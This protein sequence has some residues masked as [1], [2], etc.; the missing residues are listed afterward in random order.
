MY[1]ILIA[2]LIILIFILFAP[3]KVQLTFKDKKLVIKASLLNIPVYRVKDSVDEQKKDATTDEKAATYTRT[4][5]NLG[6]R[7]KRFADGFPTAVRMVRKYVG[8]KKIAINVELGTGDA[9]ITAIST[10]ALWAT[11]YSV[12]GIIGSVAYIDE[13]KVEITP[14]YNDKIFS[15]DIDCIIKSRIVYIIFIM[16]AILIKIHSRKGKEE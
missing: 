4:S 8:I 12:M 16:I 14:N 9:A 2:V 11:T 6:A 1:G 10:G 15:F 13:E 5:R 3:L 7:I